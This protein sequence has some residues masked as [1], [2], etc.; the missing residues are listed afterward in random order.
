MSTSNADNIEITIE[1]TPNPNTVKLVANRK[2]LSSG[3][4]NFTDQKSA[5]SSPLATRLFAIQGVKGVMFG[6]DFVSVTKSDESDWKDLHRA[7][8]EAIT[9]HLRK[10]LPVCDATGAVGC[11]CGGDGD[12]VQ[13]IRSILEKEIRPALAA[14]GGD[15]TF[16]GY[17]NGVLRVKLRGACSG[18]P[19]AAATLRMGVEAHL[20]KKIPQIRQVVSV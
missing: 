8:V 7:V 15:I 2:L 12:V 1:R 5:T 6:T 9:D 11:A 17:E 18:C 10:G 14:D 19:H 13:Q 20:R 3:A 4:I 16:E